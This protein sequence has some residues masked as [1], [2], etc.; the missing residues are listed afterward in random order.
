MLPQQTRLDWKTL[1]DSIEFSQ[2]TDNWLPL[3]RS[4]LVSVSTITTNHNINHSNNTSLQMRPYQN[5]GSTERQLETAPTQQRLSVATRPVQDPSSSQI[6][7]TYS[8]L[9]R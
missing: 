2:G 8:R 3:D 7:M 5:R 4:I 9:V 1:A 6:G